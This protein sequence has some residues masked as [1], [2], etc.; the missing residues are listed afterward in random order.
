[1]HLLVPLS[2]AGLLCF[3]LG[4]EASVLG[5]SIGPTIGGAE[6]ID[7]EVAIGFSE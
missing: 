4:L 2:F 6:S 1:M 7:R 5:L 3:C